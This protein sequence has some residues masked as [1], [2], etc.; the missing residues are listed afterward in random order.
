MNYIILVVTVR[1][2]F[3]HTPTS[4]NVWTELSLTLRTSDGIGQIFA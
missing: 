4:D 3:G 1:T 2:I